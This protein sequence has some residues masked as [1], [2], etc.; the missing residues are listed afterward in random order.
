MK[1]TDEKLKELDM[2]LSDVFR[3]SRFKI[4]NQEQ[5]TSL[6]IQRAP[7][8]GFVTIAEFYE[9]GKAE[10]VAE[11]LDKVRDVIEDLMEIRARMAGLEK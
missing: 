7:S 5:H 11:V 1:I 2:M 4:S 8:R 3:A 9:S 6:M 10:A